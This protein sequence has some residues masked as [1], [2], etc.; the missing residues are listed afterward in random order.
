MS[1]MTAALFLLATP[2]IYY[3]VDKYLMIAAGALYNIGFNTLVLLY[4]GSFNRK[5]IDLNA[6]GFGNT[7]GTSA[8]QF[9][10]ILPVL[11]IPIG[12]FYAFSI[13]FGFNAVNIPLLVEVPSRK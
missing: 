10:V 6:S 4:M 13:P 7:Q 1:I 12:L 5:Q 11:V 2:Y 8:K 9:I 3:G